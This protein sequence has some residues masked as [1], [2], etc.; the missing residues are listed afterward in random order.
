M[1][2]INDLAR[3]ISVEQVIGNT[4]L[5]LEQIQDASP[6][7]QIF[8]QSLLPVNNFLGKF[9]GHT[10]KNEAVIEVN[11]ALQKMENKKIVFID[12]H[13]S[14]VDKKG[15]LD[16]TYSNDGLHLN[17]EGYQLWASLIKKYVK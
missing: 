5:I 15:K 16:I 10:S 6:E 9:N 1:I 17:G 4:Q 13:E 2:G 14:F 3:G 7:T 8:L 11:L 12:L